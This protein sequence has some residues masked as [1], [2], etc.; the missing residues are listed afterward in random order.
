MSAR[1]QAIEGWIQEGDDL[2]ADGQ[3]HEG[4]DVMETM[5][6][7]IQP[8]V[9]LRRVENVRKRLGGPEDRVRPMNETALVLMGRRS[10]VQAFM[11]GR[12]SYGSWEI[13][14]WPMPE[15]GW[16]GSGWQVRDLRVTRMSVAELE[17]HCHITGGKIR[18]LITQKPPLEHTVRGSL[19]YLPTSQLPALEERIE[20]YKAQSRERRRAGA[21]L[22]WDQPQPPPTELSIRQLTKRS[23]IGVAAV[24]AIRGANFDL[25]WVRRGKALCLPV[26]QLPRWDRLVEEYKSGSARRQNNPGGWRR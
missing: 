22:R 26:S 10:M 8:S 14:P 25:H 7:A 20:I 18:E 13:R 24:H 17:K 19:M 12:V 6:R 4:L 3:W 9:A 1:R 15:G 11:H 16:N 5:G 2:L 21:R 23:G